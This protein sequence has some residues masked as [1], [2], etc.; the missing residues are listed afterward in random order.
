[1]VP[2]RVLVLGGWLA[3]SAHA[4]IWGH[5]DRREAHEYAPTSVERKASRSVAM[6]VPW[7]R[8]TVT[9][10]GVKLDFST[11]AQEAIA[12]E[13]PL[14]AR[15]RFHLQ[16]ASVYR[17]GSGFLVAPDV[18]VTAGHV[19]PD[20]KRCLDRAI[21]FGVEWDPATKAVR[22]IPAENVFAC[23]SVIKAALVPEPLVDY[24]VLKLDRPAKQIPVLKIRREGKISDGQSVTMIGHPWALPMKI[25]GNGLMRSNSPATHWISFLDA[26][27]GNS[28]SPVIDPKTGLVEGMLVE[29]E[30][31][32]TTIEGQWPAGCWYS[33][34]HCDPAIPYQGKCDQLGGTGSKTMR[35][36]VFA[37]SIE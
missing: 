20:T 34:V 2:L 4:A 33:K 31:G 7:S 3:A 28:G 19:V 29:G 6:M 8:L 37:K 11:L 36:T 18:V 9:A 27:P 10:A 24:A 5:D 16:P 1:M 21:V 25:T 35:T 14:C 22:P 17:V 12:I 26:Y 32:D 30:T 13:E 15:E 23:K